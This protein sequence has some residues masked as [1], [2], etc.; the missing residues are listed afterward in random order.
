[1][2]TPPFLVLPSEATAYELRTDRGG[3]AVHDARPPGGAASGTALLVPGFTGSKEDFIA[4]LGPLAEA[5]FRVVTYDQR[6]QFESGGAEPPE[7]WTTSGFAAD[8]LAVA[9]ALDAGPVHV[10]GHSFGG[11]VSRA[12]VIRDPSAFCSFVLLCSGPAGFDDERA[13]L[14]TTMA[15]GIEAIGLAGVWAITRAMEMENGWQ[16]NP[17]PAVDEFLEQRFH[18][19]DAT[20]L[21][22]MARIL[23]S[24]PDRTDELGAVCGVAPGRLPTI[25]AFGENDDAWSPKLQAET[26][27]RLGVPVVSFPKAAHSPA[28]EVPTETA[29]A[30][31]GFW[32]QPSVVGSLP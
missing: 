18:A 28:A 13:G 15:E 22:A 3:F 8:L 10:V 5:G 12:A 20:S 16:P 2:S 31:A 9:A 26:A 4:V 25:V 6:G 14:L 1:M 21:A 24:E 17:D 27:S 19:N 32:Q 30:L 29:A 23:V 7:G 11:I